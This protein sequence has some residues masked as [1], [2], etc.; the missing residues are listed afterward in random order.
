MAPKAC[1][2]LCG[3]APKN[4]PVTGMSTGLTGLNP[5]GVLYGDRAQPGKAVTECGAKDDI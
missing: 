1:E 2:P 3:V 4:S 5:P